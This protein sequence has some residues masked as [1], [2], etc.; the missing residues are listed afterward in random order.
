MKIVIEAYNCRYSYEDDHDDQNLD[1]M[2]EIFGGLLKSMGYNF[3]GIVDIVRE[4][5]TDDVDGI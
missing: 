5:G 2:C 3:N 1:E 4:E